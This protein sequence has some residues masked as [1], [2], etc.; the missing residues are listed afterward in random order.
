VTSP[1]DGEKGRSD[2]EVL[3]ELDAELEA[4][5]AQ[6]AADGPTESELEA[7]A[8]LGAEDGDEVVSTETEEW[9]APPAERR[10][11]P[12][13]EELTRTSRLPPAETAG[14][15]RG[16]DAAEQL[17]WALGAPLRWVRGFHPRKLRPGYVRRTRFPLW[18]RFTL[19]SLLIVGSTA[20]ATATSGILY[21]SDIADALGHN[22]A[23][24]ELDNQLTQ[25]D[26][27]EPQTILIL[28]SDLR[29]G[30]NDP[31]GQR[32]LSDTTI[33]L[34]L[35][36]DRDAIAMFSL[37]RDLQVNI[38]GDGLAKL[39]DA[40]LYG[41]PK[42]TLR[43]VK[44]VTG[45]EINHLVNVDFEG[46]ARAVNSIGCVYVDVDRRYFHSNAG[47][48]VQLHYDEIDVPPGY[49]ALCGFDA[50]DYVRYRHDDN[51]LVR[52][53]RQQDFLREA[54]QKVPPERLF[55]DR[56]ELIGI[57]TE[58][59][60]SDI[61]EASTM[62]QVLKLFIEARNAPVKEVHFQGHIGKSY[63]TASP[64]QIQRA[65]N[66]FLGIEA[67]GGPR[68]TS[69]APTEP[70][71]PE[72]PAPGTAPAPGAPGSAA[73][74]E[75]SRAG[76][77]DAASFAKDLAEGIARKKG[78]TPIYYPTVI[79]SGSIF[80]E[81]PRVY[82]ID[83]KDP[84]RG[85]RAAYKWVLST[86]AIGEYYG[87]MGT[88]WKDPPILRNPSETRE[89]PDG[90]ELLLFYDSDRLRLVGWKTDYG[91]FWV[92]N[93]LLQTLSQKE[94]LGIAKGMKELPRP[95]PARR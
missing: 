85:Q 86:P 94:M 60:T 70:V 25:V 53:A 5:E 36:P 20:A 77:E 32:G 7:E 33:L 48:P 54:R 58:Y 68:G 37:P 6:A 41:G 10:D 29:P 45:L 39:N 30:G 61:R 76:L 28:G 40:Y 3:D 72:T 35:D 1:D 47:L 4:L 8:G 19:A 14:P 42:L 78:K 55:T 23:L 59:T 84:P 95:A 50:L 69:A 18:A 87:M 9:D 75:Q 52:G 26:G 16:R 13:E 66:Q 56:K 65:V 57:F 27:G 74:D 83:G 79:K 81:K 49:Q 51:D 22:N 43:V 44:K 21:I 88:T 11:A 31:R 92:Q 2:D 63:V 89:I 46:F 62:L 34:R 64:A 82:K 93:T 80:E 73:K 67:S 15:G 90:R 91:S 24:A 17:V 71:A 38:P 12:D